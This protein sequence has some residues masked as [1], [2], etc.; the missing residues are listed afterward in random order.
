[1][2]IGSRRVRLVITRFY[3]IKALVTRDV[4]GL[5]PRSPALRLRAYKKTIL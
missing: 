2:A 3:V 4:E 1:M 5:Q